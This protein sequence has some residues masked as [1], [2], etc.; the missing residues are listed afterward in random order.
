[1]DI[2]INKHRWLFVGLCACMLLV[3][4]L[5]YLYM[6]YPRYSI[7]NMD[8]VEINTPLDAYIH[9]ENCDDI[10][11]QL[12]DDSGAGINTPQVNITYTCKI[13]FKSDWLTLNANVPVRFIDTTA[14]EVELALEQIELKWGE[15]FD[16]TQYIQ[17]DDNSNGLTTVEII[18]GFD[19]SIVDQYQTISANVCDESGN[20]SAV[21][22]EVIQHAPVCGDN[23]YFNGETCFCNDGYEGDGWS[24]CSAIVIQ[25]PPRPHS[26]P[27]VSA[28]VEQSSDESWNQPQSQPEQQWSAPPV[29]SNDTTDPSGWDEPDWGYNIN[30]GETDAFNQGMDACVA[31]G[32][33]DQGKPDNASGYSCLTQGNGYTLTWFDQEGNAVATI[34]G[35]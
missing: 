15:S 28:T 2:W 9:C 29:A 20:C 27:T 23:A 26:T 19:P 6:I 34:P 16:A 8:N 11:I 3:C 24:G 10:S 25:P 1:M 12:F 7:D 30:M 14:P 32:E 4:G 5:F 22:F 33:A 17:V 35:F 31:A 18:V 13:G 21:N